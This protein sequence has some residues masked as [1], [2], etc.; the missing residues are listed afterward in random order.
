M[1][2]LQGPMPGGN[3]CLVT[4]FLT[5]PQSAQ[6]CSA[7][8]I[9]SSQTAFSTPHGVIDQQQHPQL[10]TCASYDALANSDDVRLT[11]AAPSYPRFQTLYSLASDNSLSM[12]S[13]PAVSRNAASPAQPIPMR[14]GHAHLSHTPDCPQSGCESV[15]IPPRA[16]RR[17]QP[18]SPFCHDNPHVLKHAQPWQQLLGGHPHMLSAL[19][20]AT[21]E[22]HSRIVPQ[23]VWNPPPAPRRPQAKNLFSPERTNNLH[24]SKPVQSSKQLLQKLEHQS[25]TADTASS[26]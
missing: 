3:G 23:T 17:P 5:T 13:G 1:Q 10:G 21:S 9:S 2:L 18:Q 8:S 19:Q 26:H 15:L 14:A 12:L 22:T 11:P 16:P 24:T 4:P 6:L 20:S 7:Y 25:A